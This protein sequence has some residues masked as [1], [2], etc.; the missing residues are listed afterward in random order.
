MAKARI[1]PYEPGHDAPGLEGETNGRKNYWGESEAD[2]KMAGKNLVSNCRTI[3]TEQQAYAA[4]CERHYRVYRSMGMASIL[5]HA[6]V[7]PALQAL[8]S[9]FGIPASLNIVRPLVNTVT[10]MA[11]LNRPRAMWDTNGATRKTQEEARQLERVGDTLMYELDG[12]E[13]CEELVHSTAL[14]GTG[15][16]KSFEKAG[17]P[18]LDPVFTPEIVVDQIEGMYRRPRNMQRVMY[19]DVDVL[20]ELYP[21]HKDA[22]RDAPR[23]YDVDFIWWR[24]EGHSRSMVPVY[25]GTHLPDLKG[26]GGRI[27]VGTGDITLES[28]PYKDH[29]HVY[30]ELRWSLIPDRFEGMGLA[31]ELLGI[32]IEINRLV[33]QIQNSIRLFAN[34]FVFTEAHSGVEFSAFTKGMPGVRVSYVNQKPEVFVPTTVSG[35]L[36]RYL[37]LLYAKGI[38]VAGF[39]PLVM[40]G[41]TP[42][43]FS[44]G[45]A[46][47]ANVDIQNSRFAWFLKGYERSVVRIQASLL[48]V[49][50]RVNHPI[51]M[52][53]RTKLDKLEWKDINF[54]ETR[55]I[56]RPWPV[57]LLGSSPESKRDGIEWLRNNGLVTERETQLELVD[58][59]DLEKFTRRSLAGKRYVE[60][61][62]QRLLDGGEYRSPPSEVDL[63]KSIIIAQE[64]LLE[65]YYD[66]VPQRARANVQKWITH[67]RSMEEEREE[68]AKAAAKLANPPPML[69]PVA[70]PGMGMPGMPPG[71][72]APSGSIL[73]PTVGPEGVAAMTPEVPGAVPPPVDPAMI[74]AAMGGGGVA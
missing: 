7:Q 67:A 2:I 49:A 73:P 26:R 12:Y 15:Y 52:F 59:P 36:F 46:Q 55:S 6:I 66:Q 18:A 74:A 28:Q 57:A 44:S 27:V 19:V 21:E 48:R 61:E 3:L 24:N 60:D 72:A 51:K 56:M 63:K 37:E 31:E 5:P 11:A 20:G 70:P 32:Q 17:R 23:S 10:S 8:S 35:E 42:K 4:A 62:I 54:D 16:L 45:R 30:K 38:E 68:R 53:D 33:R 25:E 47:T 58:S 40:S 69:P 41:S 71:L 1:R 9:T 65:A 43:R 22:I 39:N 13:R 14:F 50:K 64:M 29:E 34:P